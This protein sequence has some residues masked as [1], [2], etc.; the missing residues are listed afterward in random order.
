V[1]RCCIFSDPDCRSICSIDRVLTLAQVVVNIFHVYNAA[2]TLKHLTLHNLPL[3]APLQH[4]HM[5]V[6][7]QISGVKTRAITLAF[8][9][10]I[11]LAYFSVSLGYFWFFSKVDL[12]PRPGCIAPKLQQT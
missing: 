1:L 2:Y 12:T 6:Q 8:T 10:V 9:F 7:A 11:T 5:H 3:A 4:V